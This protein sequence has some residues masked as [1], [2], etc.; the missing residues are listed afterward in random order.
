MHIQIVAVGRLKSGPEKTL[1]DHYIERVTFPVAVHEVEEKKK[2]SAPELKIREGELLLAEIPEGAIV[3]ALDPKGTALS[4][5]LFAQKLRGWRDTGIKSLAFLIGGA[6]GLDFP[7]LQRAN[8]ILSLGQLTWPHMLVR[9][10]LAEQ[11]YRAQ[12][13]ISGHPYHRN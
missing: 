6:E 3:V 13:I 11:I 5:E 1:Y 2:L 10:M 12:C 4:S 9:G 7:V 8:V